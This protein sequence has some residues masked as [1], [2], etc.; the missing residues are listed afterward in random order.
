LIFL[1]SL[2]ANVDSSSSDF[3]EDWLCWQRVAGTT[4]K[5]ISGT[6]EVYLDSLNVLA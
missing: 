6:L 4:T 5:L 3:D 1:P 2:T